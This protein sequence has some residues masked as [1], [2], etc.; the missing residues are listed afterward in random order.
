MTAPAPQRT[1]L[2]LLPLLPVAHEGGRT[3]NVG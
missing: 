3:V 1:V 2:P